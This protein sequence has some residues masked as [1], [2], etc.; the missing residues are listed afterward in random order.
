MKNDRV[1]DL[2]I[3]R[4][5]RKVVHFDDLRVVKS[6]AI[7][8]ERRTAG[9]AYP[10]G[11]QRRRGPGRRPILD[12][13]RA[14]NAGES[15]SVAR[16]TKMWREG[17]TTTPTAPMPIPA[18]TDVT[19]A[20]PMTP[21]LMLAILISCRPRGKRDLERASYLAPYIRLAVCEGH[22]GTAS[23]PPAS[24]AARAQRNPSL[25]RSSGDGGRSIGA[26]SLREAPRDEGACGL[27]SAPRPPR[28]S[29]SLAGCTDVRDQPSVP[30]RARS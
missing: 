9:A 28:A 4:V 23:C 15:C 2:L 27:D 29:C 5:S 19:M 14:R 7:A 22:R 12:A 30:R 1:S 6:S 20:S 11:R 17:A 3:S 8:T 25:P 24:A 16:F 10:G 26:P 18:R 21:R 13:I